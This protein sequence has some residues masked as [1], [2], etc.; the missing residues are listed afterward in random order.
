MTIL[1]AGVMGSAFAVP[2]VDNGHTV[3]LVGTHLDDDWVD[4]VAETGWHP[5][6][7]CHLPDGIKAF[8][9]DQLAEA[10][11]DD[12]DLVCLGVNSA[13]IEWGADRL[14]EVLQRN[15][16]VIMITKGLRA[17]ATGFE[18]FPTLV[19]RKLDAAGLDA[20]RVAAVA[21]PC[22]A[23]E[24]AARRESGVVFTHQDQGYL[25]WLRQLL[26]NDSYYFVRTS[27]DV[28]GVEACAAWKN[29]YA[30]AIGVP[31]GYLDVRAPAENG[32]AMHNPA[33]NLFAQA[34]SEMRLLTTFMGGSIENVLAMPGTGDLYVTCQ[35]GR[36]SR[37]GR[38][39]GAGKLY[40]DIMAG[41]MHGE[42][43]EGAELALAVGPALE[44]LCGEGRLPAERLALARAVCHAIAQNA[45]LDLPWSHFHPPPA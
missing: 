14:C 24:L 11:G 10:L 4:S 3:H 39:L 34:I 44:R 43:V 1:G 6:L 15:H 12:T 37:L 28:D 13:G 38:R 29:F 17:H 5:K 26:A 9:N 21:G 7:R 25:D 32:A 30:L 45:P 20:S 42:T 31:S 16:P 41:P 23:G 27:T 22:I 2:A 18:N 35:G 8:R 40:R 33:A 36:N 19:A